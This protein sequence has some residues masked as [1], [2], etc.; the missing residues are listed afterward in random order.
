[1][2]WTAPWEPCLVVAGRSCGRCFLISWVGRC[3]R[4]SLLHG[5]D[6][7]EQRDQACEWARVA[8]CWLRILVCIPVHGGFR[9][10][11]H[12]SGRSFWIFFCDRFAR[13]GDAGSSV[14]AS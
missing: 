12:E 7:P 1:M 10:L 2:V 13:V 4:F 8:G 3:S 9:G 6:C 5:P 14:A 11:L